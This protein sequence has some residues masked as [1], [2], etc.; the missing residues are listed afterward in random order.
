[1]WKKKISNLLQIN[2]SLSDSN[3]VAF[4]KLRSI[5]AKEISLNYKLSLLATKSDVVF[6]NL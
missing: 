2:D 3:P 6:E 5:A 4:N 1:M